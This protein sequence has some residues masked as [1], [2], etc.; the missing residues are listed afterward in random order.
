MYLV[1]GDPVKERRDRIKGNMTPEQKKAY[2]LLYANDDLGFIIQKRT[3]REKNVG[4]VFVCSVHDGVYYYGKILKVGVEHERLI[5]SEGCLLVCIYRECTN[6]KTLDDFK[7]NAND[8]M[9]SPKIV[10]P[11]YW[12]NGYFETIGNV[13]LT[14][15]EKE[16]DYGFWEQKILKEEGCFVKEDGTCLDHKPKYFDIFGTSLYLGIYRE[17]KKALIIDPSLGIVKKN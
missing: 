11:Q 15:A 9:F 13:P 14:K 8:L 4:D 2:E 6:K 7:G 1:K 17:I 3:R 16:L 5:P 12:S 10:Y